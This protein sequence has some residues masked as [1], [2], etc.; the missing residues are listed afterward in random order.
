[1]FTKERV[2]DSDAQ[3]SVDL[4]RRAPQ[5]PNTSQHRHEYL[6]AVDISATEVL[7]THDLASGSLHQR[8][9]TQEDRTIA[10]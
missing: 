6:L 8:R 2:N 7:R 10:C 3:R 4:N 1:M 5:R 9:A